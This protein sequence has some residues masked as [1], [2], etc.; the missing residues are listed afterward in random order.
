[1]LRPVNRKNSLF[2]SLL[3]KASARL[4]KS[5]PDTGWQAKMPV[6]SAPWSFSGTNA[7]SDTL[8]QSRDAYA[9][10]AGDYDE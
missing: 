7:A 9:F 6:F 4:P 5:L 2:S 8:M 10:V 3:E 1:V